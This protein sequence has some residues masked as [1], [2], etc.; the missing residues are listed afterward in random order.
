MRRGFERSFSLHQILSRLTTSGVFVAVLVISVFAQ[1]ALFISGSSWIPASDQSIITILE[2]EGYTVTT[3]PAADS[4]T[5]DADGMDLIWISSN[6]SSGQVNTKFTS[7]AVPIINCEGWLYD[8]LGMTDN[9]GS[10]TV[11]D[12]DIIDSS[13]PLAG[14]QSGTTRLF[15]NGANDIYFG[16]P[17]ANGIIVAALTYDQSKAV[18]FG[19]E[20]GAVMDNGT[21]PARRV[22]FFLGDNGGQFLTAAGTNLVSAAIQWATG[23]DETVQYT[24][25]T[26]VMGV[27]QSEASIILDPPGGVYPEGTEVT[28]RPWAAEHGYIFEEWSGGVYTEDWV[29]TFT[30]DRDMDIFG[31]FSD[32]ILYNI[33]TIPDPVE[34]GVS[35]PLDRN[36]QPQHTYR[37]T[38][39][40]NPGY[41]FVKWTANIDNF[42]DTLYWEGYEDTF[43]LVVSGEALYT[44]HFRYIG[45][46]FLI[47][48]STMGTG[49]GVVSLNPDQPSYPYGSVVEVTAIPANDGSVFSGWSGSISGTQNPVTVTVNSDLTITANFTI[50]NSEVVDGDLL[51]N[52]KIGVGTDNPL[53][54][55]DVDGTIRSE[56][57]IVETVGGADYVF[58]HDYDLKDL[59]DVHAFVSENKHLPGIASEK[60]MVENGIN[61]KALTIKLLEKIEELTLY[62]IKQE[63]E[64]NKLKAKIEK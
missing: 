51:V 30:V 37:L 64:I 31:R 16:K 52:G 34:G 15:T 24:V 5:S 17:N 18:I 42:Y 19:Y 47:S 9:Y 55:I 48:T 61:L 58:D 32:S 41:E 60:E 36:V 28:I 7:V 43:D 39:T 44:A 4:R 14:N 1:N 26:H 21:A 33:S 12:V 46:D 59:A 25:T 53:Y 38:A 8:D 49:T 23:S 40:A 50:G 11:Q 54:A 45:E 13:H 57:I 3:V 22:G 29:T 35:T 62:T 27:P 2:S 56:E 20:Q 6:I 63:N 10:V